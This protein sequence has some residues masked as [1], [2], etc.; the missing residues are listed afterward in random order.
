VRYEIGLFR[1]GDDEAA[2]TGH[3][4]H[5][6]VD[7]DSQRPVPIPSAIRAALEPLVEGA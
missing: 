4:V 6:W 7:R 5:V 2:A 1:Q 3:F